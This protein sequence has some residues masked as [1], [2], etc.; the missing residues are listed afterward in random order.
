MY[1]IKFAGMTSPA[2]ILIWSIGMNI[3]TIKLAFRGL[4]V[5]VALAAPGI[6]WAGDHYLGLINVSNTVSGACTSTIPNTVLADKA[7]VDGGSGVVS[8]EPLTLSGLCTGSENSKATVDFTGNLTLQFR[9]VKMCKSWTAKNNTTVYGWLDQG[10]TRIGATGTLTG[11]QGGNYRVELTMTP[12]VPVSTA[13]GTCTAANQG[14]YDYTVTRSAT[15]VRN[16]DTFTLATA[17]FTFGNTAPQGN[18]P[19]PGTL[20]LI[21]LGLA[22]LGWM[23]A[24]RARK[25]RASTI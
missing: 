12:P 1:F 9:P 3:H 25:T 20:S 17:N 23:G 16:S 19:E 18:V 2:S 22:G 4:A 6:G 11:S 21:G 10:N 24:R 5:A 14:A 7:I 15:V 8:S 13:E